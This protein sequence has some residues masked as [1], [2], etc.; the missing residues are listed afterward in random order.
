MTI[1]TESSFINY[2]GNGATTVFTFPFVSGGDPSDI[3]VIYTAVNG[4]ATTLSP[5]QYTL[6]FN[7]IPIGGLWSIGGSVTYP[8]SGTP[9]QVGTELTINRVVP[10]EQTISISNQG[11]FYPQAIEQALDLLELQI[12]Q[13]NTQG[14]YSLRFPL[15][16]PSPPNILPSYSVRA[17]GFLGFDGVGQPIILQTIPGGG[18]SIPTLTGI[19]RIVNISTTITVGASTNDAFNGISIY[20]SGSAVTTVQ[21]PASPSGPITVFDSS[22]NAGTFPITI[23]PPAGKTINGASSYIINFSGQVSTFYNDGNQALRY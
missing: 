10:F 11:N 23:L 4:I 1:S 15:S 17:N 3:E 21:L 13:I 18:G 8:I 5:S 20:Q 2:V 19:P 7:S 9:I 16:D 22:N 6:L 14:I 12:Q